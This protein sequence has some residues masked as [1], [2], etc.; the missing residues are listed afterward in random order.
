MVT[1]LCCMCKVEK[2]L[3]TA[4]AKNKS[5]SLGK[6]YECKECRKILYTKRMSDPENKQKK[7]EQVKNYKKTQEFKE[8]RNLLE[9]K[10]RNNDPQYKMIINLRNRCRKAFLGFYKD[11]T[12][13][14]LLG[15]SLEELQS[16]IESKFQF[17]MTMD[18]YG[19]WHLDH[20]IPLSSAKGSIELE[21]LCHYTN[22]QPLWAKDNLIKS[23]KR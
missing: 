20:I 18:N 13:K 15:C 10:R 23:N 6:Q 14:K 9:K 5:M 8:R 7:L 21:Q 4:F 11:K 17:G 1:R 16:Y 19:E 22:L 2:D 12:T 3:E